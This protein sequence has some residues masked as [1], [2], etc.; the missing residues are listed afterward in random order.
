[1][2]KTQKEVIRIMEK[3]GNKLIR[4][5]GGFWTYEGATIRYRPFGDH[6]VPVWYCG[7][8]TLRA[9][10]KKGLVRLDELQK[11]CVRIKGGE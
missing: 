2:S 6:P 9:M 11:I 4:W 10:H 3:Y 7:V 1:M 8:R 5:P